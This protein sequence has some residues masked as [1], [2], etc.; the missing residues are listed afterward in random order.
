MYI[1][2]EKKMLISLVI[3]VMLLSVFSVQSY[4]INEQKVEPIKNEDIYNNTKGDKNGGYM[5]GDDVME[6]VTMD[7]FSD[8]VEKKGFEIIKFMKV[9]ANPFF[10]ICFIVALIFT[11]IGA[12]CKRGGFLWIGISAMIIVAF[13]Y[14]AVIYSSDILRWVQTWIVS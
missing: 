4:A 10:T 1:A 2:L 5:T 6:K 3:I 7:E 9:F 13:S 12:F 8:R 11:A 14:T